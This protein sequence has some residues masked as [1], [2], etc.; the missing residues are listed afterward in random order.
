MRNFFKSLLAKYMFIILVALF[1]VQAGYLIIALFIYGVAENV[2]NHYISEG[3]DTSTIEEKWHEEAEELDGISEELI[4][5]HFTKWQ[6][7][8]PEATMFWVDGSNQLRV[9]VGDNEN[10]PKEWSA[11][12]TAA[13]IKER[14]GGDPFTV[15]SI[16]NEEDGFLVF[17]IPREVFE[18]PAQK[19]YDRYGDILLV[20]VV[21]IVTLFIAISF[22]FFHRIRKRLL[23]LQEAMEIRD[24]DG[25]PLAIPVKKN[26]E[27]GQLEET[28]NRMVSELRE[29]RM[30]EQEEEQLRKELI[31]NL[32]HDLRTPLTKIRAQSYSI[33]KGDIPEES[34]QSVQ[35]MERS[36]QDMDRLI[37]NL[38]SYTLLTASK[39]QMKQEKVDLVRFV[40]KHIATWYPVFEKDGFK[41]N[42]CLN[43]LRNKYWEVDPMWTARIIDNLLQNV[44][45]HAKS[46][47][48]VEVRTEATDE[49]DALLI[50]DKGRGI[51]SK[52]D[53]SGAGIGLSIV[54][55]MVKGMEL[56]WK[57]TSNSQG[58]VVTI[59]K[60]HTN[61]S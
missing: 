39:Y 45:R 15:I 55:M 34:R 59:M 4:H 8:L 20:G 12:N 13:F 38:M 48:Y 58:T 57:I 32:S 24:V 18:L 29:S 27:I 44:L 21:L 5:G 46:G 6:Q 54:D 11:T 53:Q 51:E 7:D 23:N 9:L 47:K 61:E 37:E 28:F 17:E 35:Q 33:A 36:I 1:L 52:S 14:Y 3:M 19:I 40:R 10:I 49:Y 60:K 56:D 42:V 31:A 2:G 25:L 16:L 30:R 41:I 22:L 43:P 26:D 50:I